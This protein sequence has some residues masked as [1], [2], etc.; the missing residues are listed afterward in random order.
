MDELNTVK[1]WAKKGLLTNNQYNDDKYSR[2]INFFEWIDIS[3]NTDPV[4]YQQQLSQKEVL[5]VGMGGIGG[6]ID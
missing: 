5:I 3:E 6:N 2:N 1:K 4:K